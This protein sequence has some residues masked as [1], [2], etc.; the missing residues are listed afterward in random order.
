MKGLSCILLLQQ[1]WHQTLS[2]GGTGGI[3]QKEEALSSSVVQS[4][5]HV[6]LFATPWTTAYHASLSFTI[7]QSLLKLRSIELMMPS[8]NFILCCPF[9]SCPQSF[10]VSG[11]FPMSRLFASGNQSIGASA[12]ASVFPM[13]IHGWFPLGLTGWI[14]FLSKGLSR[15]FSITTIQKHQFFGGQPSL[16]SNSHIHTWPLEKP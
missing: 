13:N 10:P 5:S 7:S 16:W 15:G 3:L 2:L 1:A 4:L 11:S 14:S 8:N 6:Q 9:S 12:S